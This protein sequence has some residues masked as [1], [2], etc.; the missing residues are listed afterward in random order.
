MMKL[1][2]VRIVLFLILVLQTVSAGADPVD[3]ERARRY[4]MES[5]LLP[6]LAEKPGDMHRKTRG[7]V[8]RK[9]SLDLVYTVRQ[10]SGNA[11]TP[12]LYVFSPASQKG[13]VVIAAD[14][15][16]SPVVGY[17]PDNAFDAAAMPPQF[18]TFLDA[19]GQ[20]VAE[21]A[22]QTD[23]AS[24]A[25]A[26]ATN[27]RSPISPLLDNILWGQD[28]PYN[29]L[30]PVLS[31]EHTPTGCV[32]TAL[33]QI[34]YYHKF[35]VHATG[36]SHYGFA[37]MF[38]RGKTVVFGERGD[39]QWD[40]MRP[41][42]PAGVSLTED[43]G[44]A[45]A[46]LM[47]EVGA[48]CNMK[49]SPVESSTSGTY[50]LK[51]LQKHLGYTSARLVRRMNKTAEE[52]ENLIYGELAEKRPVY[53]DGCAAELGHAFVC[54]GY[55]ANGYFHINWGWDGRANGYFNFSYLM[56]RTR[57]TGGSGKGAY[58][59]DLQA[60][61]GIAPPEKV[62]TPYPT[63]EL[64]AKT[65]E[66]NEAYSDSYPKF[67]IR[68]VRLE[69]YEDIDAD[70]SLGIRKQDGTLINVGTPSAWTIQK[71]YTY[72]RI[73]VTLVPEN[74]PEGTYPLLPIFSPKQKG[75]WREIP[76]G[77]Y[78]DRTV[79][80]SKTNGRFTA[81]EKKEPV[82]L[83]ASLENPFVFAGVDNTVK[84]R[85]EN[86]GKAA[87]S[88]FVSVYFGQQKI[89]KETK[90]DKAL[91]KGQTIAVH[92]EPGESR[93]FTAEYMPSAGVGE[94]YASVTY[95]PTNG[96]SDEATIIPCTVLQSDRIET[97][98]AD[99]YEGRLSAK[100]DQEVYTVDGYTP[101][102]VGIKATSET[103]GGYIGSFAHLQ[104]FVIGSDREKYRYKF[105]EFEVLLEKN[106]T[107]DYEVNGDLHL[108]E[109]EYKL[110]L[111]K[112]VRN[113][114]NIEY[115]TMSE[116]VLKVLPPKAETS[117][118]TSVSGVASDGNAIVPAISQGVLSIRGGGQVRSV[119]VF[120]LSGIKVAH[121]V[122][123]PTIDLS[124]LP[125]GIYVVRAETEKGVRTM[126]IAYNI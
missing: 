111:T 120:S 112:N 1:T 42:Y 82:S 114:R 20:H 122:G 66:K 75:Q 8:R 76:L 40:K 91:V 35:P 69:G 110:L 68:G 117:T 108:E 31:G 73:D 124:R 56:P 21:A 59:V 43:E 83:S 100:F 51:A 61:V 47:A 58:V 23:G 60:I 63:H 79:T 67:N 71:D 77:R 88:S 102:H 99:L 125:G 18:K 123:S 33:A 37:N 106:Q 80:V 49:Y 86:R 96:L 90:V 74:V 98:K 22:V 10:Q 93:E 45:V 50:A 72:N 44:N 52:W 9:S 95:D 13:Y 54:D 24:Q 65:I 30:T 57:G 92:L 121:A 11:S 46:L 41:N 19:M 17:S 115:T 97:K 94:C 70:F 39:Y 78:F 118:V 116:A 38:V 4:A 3:V 6:E 107:K 26:V 103:Y 25:K 104:L 5:G 105:P 15:A 34:M 109:G 12:L 101:L 87:Y 53:L 2:H 27:H 119:S 89:D 126:K 85:I 81:V 36:S 32:A 28:E 55:D 16:V 29:R 113:G 84:F 62:K 64:L 14:D 48:A 7:Y